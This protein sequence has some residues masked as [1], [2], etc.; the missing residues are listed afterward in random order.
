LNKTGTGA[1]APLVIANAGTGDDITGPDFSFNGNG[2]FAVVEL[3]T[4]ATINATDGDLELSVS[5]STTTIQGTLTIDEAATFAADVVLSD[6][7]ITMTDADEASTLAIVNNTA[8][9]VNV[10]S[11]T[12]DAIA[13]GGSLLYLDSLA[14]GMST[15][16]FINC[17]DNA[18]TVFSVGD[19]GATVI[20]GVAA[21]NV[22]T[23]TAGD[24]LMSAGGIA[25]TKAANNAT[26][27]LTN[28]SLTSASG[29]V[30]AG[31]GTFTGTTTTSFMT[32]TP[33]GMTSGTG[34]YLPLAACNTGT[35][36]Q[37]VANALTSGQAVEITS[38]ATTLAT[39]GR[40]FSSVHSGNAG[41][42]CVVNEFSSAAADETTIL[43]VSASAALAGGVILDV[44]GAALT[45]GTC[46]DMSGLAA[47]TDGKAIHIDATGV[48]H[49]DGILVH[50]DS[51]STAIKGN[52]RLLLVDHT[53]AT[54]VSGVIAEFAT[55]ATDETVLVRLDASSTLQTG[56]MLEMVGSSVTTGGF[57]EAVAIDA[58]STGIVLHLESGATAITTT[59]R[60]AY[61]NHTG[62]AST[63]GTLVE[64]ASAA[65]DETVIFQLTASA[66]LAAGVVAKVTAA[67]MTTGTAIEI[68]GLDALTDGIGLDIETA[69]TTMTAT[70]RL[71]S[72]DHSGNASTSG[73]LSEFKSAAADETVMVQINATA[74]LAAGVA[75]KLIGTSVTTG[76]IIAA[77]ALD[78]LTDGIG[79][80][81]ESGSNVITS[82][83][84][85]AYFNHTGTASV[86]GVLIKGLTAAADETV[87]L[88]LT[89]S[90]TITGSM[91]S[92][93]ADSSVTGKGIDMS[94]D[95]LTTGVMVNL[96][97]DSSDT[98]ARDLL[99]IHNDNTAAVATVPLTI[100]QDALVSTNFKKVGTFA[101]I[102]I[103]VSD[104][105]SPNGALTGTTGD[106]CLAGTGGATFYA[107]NG[108]GQVWASM[109]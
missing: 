80:H 8:A 99:H 106:I 60:L 42:D 33:S 79:L 91:I 107:S 97:S 65:A 43:R 62:N 90:S 38:S 96:H 52:G 84:G 89:A 102:S 36:L 92:I 94:M 9:A 61:L 98:T 95:G 53:N 70:G 10:V 85:L 20:A 55:D 59:G 22:F 26:F 49:D 23:I 67:S 31:S 93:V 39:T 45:T 76:D 105:T 25:I 81:V 86:S 109:A 4:G 72:V 37:V 35:G 48:T 78:A 103:W 73:I 41:T 54:T 2:T 75:L 46:I 28:N 14:A 88:G 44:S 34:V 83:G 16:L 15:G 30:I 82:T 58:L 101:G 71:L 47:L 24:V 19:N 18:A 74:A 104:G 11:V 56:V 57:I 7:S 50:I 51:G 6:G 1:G 21:G 69:S 63:S 68:D 5:G 3:G 40:L 87:M 100:V 108:A 13:A 64:I 66:A 32:I 77:E 12:A 17:Y 27:S 29:V